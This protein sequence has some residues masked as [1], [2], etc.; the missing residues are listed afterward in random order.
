MGEP[1]GEVG[2]S[3]EARPWW[4]EATP[5]APLLLAFVKL[6]RHGSTGEWKELPPEEVLRRRARYT[7]GVEYI[8]EQFEAAQPLQWQGDG[9]M[10]FFRGDARQS[11]VV[12]AFEAAKALH[13]RL[14]MDLGMEARLAVH[15]AVVAWNP[16]AG[17]LAHPAIDLCGHLEHDAPINSIAVTED[18]YL[19]LPEAERRQLALLGVTVRDGIAAYVFPAG[20]ESRKS[21][22]TFREGAGLKLWE[23]FRAYATGP[24][25]RLLRYVGFPLQKKQP[26]SLDIREVFTPPDGGERSRRMGSPVELAHALAGKE[27]PAEFDK[28]VAALGELPAASAPEPVSKL[29]ARHRALVVLGDPGS[30]KTTV[31]R[32]LAVMAAAGPIALLDQIG[33]AE[34]LLPVLVSVGRLAD[35]RR[36]LGEGC[37]VLNA[38]ARYFQDRNV[39]QE[40]ELRGFLEGRLEAG[41]CLVLLD[42]LDEV[43]GEERNG[44]LRW[45]EMFCAQYPRSRFVASSRLVGYAGFA[46]PG[47]VE[48][49]LHRFNDKQLRRYITALMRAFR[50][51]ELGTPD[52]LNADREAQD[53]LDALLGNP[54]LH[55]LAR[56]PL[57]LSSL[58]LIHRAEGRLPRHRV[59]AYEIFSRTLCETWGQARRLVAS[60]GGLTDIRYEEEA[61]PI[62]GD[63]ALR[64][65]EEWPAGVAPEDFVLWVLADAIRERGDG[66]PGSAERAA[67]E[68]L[69]R[70]GRDVQMLLDQGAGQ[71][72]FLHLT[73]QEFFAAAGLLS[74]ER[75]EEEAFKHLF[76]PRWEE[77]LRL[78]VGYMALIQKRAAAVERIVRKVLAHRERG[79]RKFLTELLQKHIYLAALLANEAGDVL[80]VP[81]Q[82][83]VTKAVVEWVRVMPESVGDPL[84]R[85][86]GRGTLRP[87]L[88]ATFAPLATG[89]VQE[90][91]RARAVGALGTVGGSDVL[92]I[93]LR[94]R[95]DSSRLVQLASIL[96]ENIIRLD[97][98]RAS[99]LLYPSPEDYHEEFQE[100]AIDAL[101]PLLKLAE[102]NPQDR[103]KIIAA[104][105]KIAAREAPSSPRRL[106]SRR[107]R[108]RQPRKT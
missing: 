49:T 47:A 30:G 46:L 92:E 61:L 38:L 94:A 6:D 62:L 11:A 95:S 108:P 103:K 15:A 29:A 39:G 72:G 33:L 26:P 55:D 13:Q 35:I 89:A 97:E 101:Q 45:L 78:G 18:V 51:W 20:L 75:F 27:L 90:D 98:I 53:L 79:S 83:E 19:S 73:F 63:L 69:Q 67:K 10:L 70:A 40:R 2:S 102:A 43:R 91:E 107:R 21:T 42:G 17:K 58:A 12:R 54:R 77:V 96:A 86:L 57:L 99:L 65:H 14:R 105:W 16:Q 74:S 24:D 32:W 68:F 48:V 37:A 81:L 3:I 52:D 76:D 34:R 88:V 80:P 7:S 23:R 66:A 84:L 31:L 44:V 93:V 25:V 50:R 41:E 104:V 82:E 60:E 87:R 56:N 28:A 9:V 5:G 85:E 4:E 1:P 100:S 59:Q 36:T 64:M 106:A 71:W 22:E 8:A